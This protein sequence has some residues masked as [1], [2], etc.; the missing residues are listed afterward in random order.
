[1]IDLGFLYRAYVD[2]LYARR[3]VTRSAE[4]IRN[5]RTMGN[6]KRYSKLYLMSVRHRF[7]TYSKLHQNVLRWLIISSGYDDPVLHPVRLVLSEGTGGG[8]TAGAEAAHLRA[9]Q[10]H[11]LRHRV[12]GPHRGGEDG[13]HREVQHDLLQNPRGQV[14]AAD[15]RGHFEGAVLEEKMLTLKLRKNL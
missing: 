3:W 14:R 12:R 10:R 6:W 13:E 9:G 4:P 15:H 7:S 8:Q 1:M 5:E 2:H 11:L